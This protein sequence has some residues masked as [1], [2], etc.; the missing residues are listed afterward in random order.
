[1]RKLMTGAAMI[2]LGVSLGA[3][4]EK[5]PEAEANVAAEM[6]APAIAEPAAPANDANMV[7]DA[8]AMNNVTEQGSTDHGSTD[9]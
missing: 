9:H 3:C 2:A 6:N 8:A 5:A 1:M 7:D 4:R